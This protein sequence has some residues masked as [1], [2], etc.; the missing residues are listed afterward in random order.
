[1]HVRMG[2]VCAGLLKNVLWLPALMTR[3]GLVQKKTLP[4]PPPASARVGSLH[5]AALVREL[6]TDTNIA[7]EPGE[8][9]QEPRDWVI[10]RTT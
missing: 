9:P 1:V 2:G 3:D 7:Y 4:S 8:G 6:R 5:A 10:F